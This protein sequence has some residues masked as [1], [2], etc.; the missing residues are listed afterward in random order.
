MRRTP[1]C[2]QLL[3][4]PLLQRLVGTD[5]DAIAPATNLLDGEPMTGGRLTHLDLELG[6][7]CDRI[8]PTTVLQRCHAKRCRLVDRFGG[9][10]N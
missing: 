8:S 9:D 7:R 10:I 4:P 2:E 6:T 3:Q 5:R 1:S